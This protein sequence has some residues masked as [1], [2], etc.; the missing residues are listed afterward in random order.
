M[1]ILKIEF[2]TIFLRRSPT[3][4]AQIHV[5]NCNNIKLK[6]EIYSEKLWCKIE[7]LRQRMHSG[8][9]GVCV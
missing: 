8:S 6:K 1:A 4:F 7:I 9:V 3:K 2:K 5:Y